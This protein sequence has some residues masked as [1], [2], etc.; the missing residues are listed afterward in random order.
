MSIAVHLKRLDV[1]QND[2][3]RLQQVFTDK[4]NSRKLRKTDGWYLL[5]SIFFID[6]PTQFTSIL[7]IMT[8]ILP[9]RDKVSHF[10]HYLYLKLT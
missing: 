5:M 2:T 3:Y 1:Y 10:N 7:Q 8:T 4:N 6:V 9:R